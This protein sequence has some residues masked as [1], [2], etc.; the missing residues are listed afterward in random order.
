[1]IAHLAPRSR[2]THVKD[3][4]GIA[5]DHEFLI[6]GEGEMDYPRYLRA[7]DKAGYDGHIVVEISLM[8]QRRPH[9]DPLAAAAQSYAVLSHA[10]AEAAVP[11]QRET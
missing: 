10:F 9:Y 4:R 2:H 11:W 6:P 8:V 7:M 5:P 1:V 3:E